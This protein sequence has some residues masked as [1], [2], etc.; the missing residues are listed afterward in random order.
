MIDNNC[1][2][3]DLQTIV[4]HGCLEMLLLQSSKL[5]FCWEFH[6]QGCYGIVKLGGVFLVSLRD[7]SLQRRSC[8][9]V[10]FIAQQK[11]REKQSRTLES[12]SNDKRSLLCSSGAMNFE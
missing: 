4:A 11:K 6:L 12:L 10:A 5:K 2:K 3:I 9:N 7:L 1:E 8:Q